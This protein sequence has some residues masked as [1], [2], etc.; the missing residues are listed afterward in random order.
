[1][2]L[3]NNKSTIHSG[4]TLMFVLLLVSLFLISAVFPFRADMMRWILI[5]D[6][7]WHIGTEMVL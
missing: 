7:T 1:M 2:R 3:D 5:V 6:G 4:I